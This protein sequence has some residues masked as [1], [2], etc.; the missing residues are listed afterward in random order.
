MKKKAW[1]QYRQGKI[2]VFLVGVLYIS[3][4]FALVDVPG[5]AGVHW[6]SG[7]ATLILAAFSCF[8]VVLWPSNRVVRAASAALVVAAAG[9]RSVSTLF[10]FGLGPALVWLLVVVLL[11]GTWTYVLPAP[12]PPPGARGD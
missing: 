7:N 5:F 3:L 8:A 6:M 4:A 10:E 2:T 1:R 9:W 12:V 11:V